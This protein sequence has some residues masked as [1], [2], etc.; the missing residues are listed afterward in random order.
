MIPLLRQIKL[1][2]W[3]IDD[4]LYLERDYVKSGFDAVGV[5]LH[6]E[7]GVAGFGPVAWRLF[8]EGIRGDTF[9]RALRALGVED[10]LSLIKALVKVYRE[11]A[12]K[13]ELLPDALQVLR[14]YKESHRHAAITDGPE[15]SQAAKV[16]ALKLEAWA[17][18]CVLTARL[19]P[20]HGK[21]ST[22]SFELIQAHHQLAGEH[23]LY[24]G[25]NPMKDFI[26]PKALGWST[27]RVRRPGS[28]HEALDSAYDVN[29]ELPD[30]ELLL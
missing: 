14:E 25:D 28:L 2:V 11:H 10:E 26:G 13:I 15:P 7:R 30:L 3:D 24:I 27:L 22:K 9:N 21:P 29:L 18:P 19:G 6:S 4:T 16:A 1:I 17:E 12:P 5:W 8:E 23:C 20:G